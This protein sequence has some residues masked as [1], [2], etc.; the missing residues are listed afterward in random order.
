MKT[1]LLWYTKGNLGDFILACY[2][3]M[4]IDL[5]LVDVT[6]CT[7]KN[8][9]KIIRDLQLPFKIIE[10]NN[11]IIS[12]IKSFA[13]LKALNIFVRKI[14]SC[15]NSYDVSID[16]Y[17]WRSGFLIEQSISFFDSIKLNR[18]NSK[19]I[20][21]FSRA[22]LAIHEQFL[23]LAKIPYAKKSFFL[24]HIKN[25]TKG[26]ELVKRFDVIIHPFS[27]E[28]T[29]VLN[30]EFVLE[31]VKMHPN[32]EILLLGVPSDD[33]SLLL[34]LKNL[35][36]ENLTV[37]IK[38]FNFFELA[39]LIIAAKIIYGSESFVSN[40]ASLLGAKVYGF[41]S[42]VADPNQW[43]LP[44]FNSTTFKLNVPCSP[45]FN[46]IACSNECLNFFAFSETQSTDLNEMDK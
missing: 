28:K 41:F 43:Y 18:F 5:A 15:W 1:K 3:L 27:S 30:Y 45:C 2:S 42:G 31:I 38:Y 35:K 36:L 37:E 25:V 12:S 29:R 46:K 17:R 8:N 4:K 19:K 21:N 11:T 32:E 23:M 16:T 9:I 13:L 20:I 34:K 33:G 40:F 24:H 6:I 26:N 22:E 14:C 7:N 44:G 10:E 39:Q